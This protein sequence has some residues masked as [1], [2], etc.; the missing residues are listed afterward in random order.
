MS[1]ATPPALAAPHGT[2]HVGASNGYADLFAE[3]IA[4]SMAVSL[5]VVRGT[6]TKLLDAD[7][8]QACHIL[9]YALRGAQRYVILKVLPPA[10]R[11]EARS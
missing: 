3:Y 9:D 5:A 11:Y 7:W 2:A 10:L 4:R 6:E 8:V 1:A